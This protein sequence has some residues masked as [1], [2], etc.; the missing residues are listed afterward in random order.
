M[1]HETSS[2]SAQ[3]WSVHA[4]WDHTEL[5]V[6]NTFYTLKGSATTGNLHPQSSRAVTHCLLIARPTH[7]TDPRDD[8]MIACVKL[9]GV[10]PGVEPG[11]LAS[12]ASVLP[13]SHLLYLCLA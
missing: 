2:R 5:P 12:E 8:P 9:A 11:P 10:P 7:F 6:T 1:L 4:E 13:H 3:A